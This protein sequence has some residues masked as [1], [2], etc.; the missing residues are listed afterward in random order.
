VPNV[1]GSGRPIAENPESAGPPRAIE[2]TI[3]AA[4][5][6]EAPGGPVVGKRRGG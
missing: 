2:I 4:G 3:E 5:G 6:S 1:D